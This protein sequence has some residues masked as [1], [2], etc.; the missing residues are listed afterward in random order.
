MEGDNGES[1]G[2]SWPGL[3]GI[4]GEQKG[5]SSGKQKGSQ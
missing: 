1:R 5:Q 4:E 2:G 3:S